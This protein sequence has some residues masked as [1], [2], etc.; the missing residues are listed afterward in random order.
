M[1]EP[2]AGLTAYK[3]QQLRQFGSHFATMA[4]T[5]QTKRKYKSKEEEEAAR[6]RLEQEAREKAEARK[7]K[8]PDDEKDFE[9]AQRKKRTEEEADKE[10]LGC[11][12][13]SIRCYLKTSLNPPLLLQPQ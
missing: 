1:A 7:R 5:K 3:K 6:K 10:K 11:K 9:E 13:R 4:H 8:K 12:E 2:Q